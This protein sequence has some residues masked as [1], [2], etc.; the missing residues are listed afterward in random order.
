M[1]STNDAVLRWLRELVQRRGLNTAE[2][3]RK[4][5]IA[6]GRLRRLLT[7]G[8]AMLVD[9][10]MQISSAL[11]LSPAELGL[12]EVSEDVE[13][14]VG[15]S[16]PSP[17]PADGI[18]VDPFADHARQ[19]FEVGFALGCTFFF[20]ARV[21]DLVDS[22]VPD[23]ILDGH[24]ERG[25]LVISLDAAYH[26]DNNPRIADDSIVLTLSFDSLYDC[27]FPWSSI[28]RVV[29][30]VEVEAASDE[31]PSPGP[32]PHLRLVT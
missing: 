4:A 19:L 31:G 28:V 15:L 21:S 20:A 26:R 16:S 17:A 7:G 2:L 27:S 29:F 11:E 22:G 14:P 3:A 13:L 25:E 12:P 23:A 8:E 18:G 1:S 24:R 32:G 5:G 10:L 30:D 6:R 9:E